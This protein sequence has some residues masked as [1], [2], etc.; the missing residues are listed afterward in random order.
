MPVMYVLNLKLVKHYLQRDGIPLLFITKEVDG[1]ADRLPIRILSLKE[2]LSY[3]IKQ[4]EPA[5]MPGHR[6]G[7]RILDVTVQFHQFLQGGKLRAK[8]QGRLAAASNGAL[9]NLMQTPVKLAT[10]ARRGI[11]IAE[12]VGFHQDPAWAY[13][14]K[15]GVQFEEVSF[16]TP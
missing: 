3:R 13:P 10:F 8:E 5:S 15:E 12:F 7:E 14:I 1:P 2:V 11:N 6:P 4:A 16:F 9:L